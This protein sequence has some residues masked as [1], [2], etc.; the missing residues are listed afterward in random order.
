MWVSECVIY[1]FNKNKNKQQN[2][3]FVTT[4]FFF[5][6]N[7]NFYYHSEHWTQ[8][9]GA[10]ISQTQEHRPPMSIKLQKGHT[11]VNVELDWDWDV[12][13]TPVEAQSNQ[14]SLLTLMWRTPL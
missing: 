11:E 14:S 9:Y 13:N 1:I 6:C 8:C 4:I 2:Q 7:N 5:F 12:E 3:Q 10:Q